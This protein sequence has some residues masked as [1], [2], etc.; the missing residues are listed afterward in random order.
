MTG[1][2][3]CVPRGPG[4]GIDS[5]PFCFYFRFYFWFYFFLY[6]SRWREFSSDPR[7]TYKPEAPQ[8]HAFA[9][10][11][12]QFFVLPLVLFVLFS[13]P[14]FFTLFAAVPAGL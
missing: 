9:R 13:F 4:P 3:F 10:H 1:T 8:W 7:L 14:L 5:F 12:R 11:R 2:L 6:E